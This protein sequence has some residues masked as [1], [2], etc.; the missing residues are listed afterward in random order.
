MDFF[1]HQSRAKSQS[2][3]LYFL[4]SFVVLV[5]CL[6]VFCLISWFIGESEN[7]KD[8]AW[9]P[10]LLFLT[11][12]V[13]SATIISVSLSKIKE[14][15]GGGW[16]IAN[17]LGGQLITSNSLHPLKRRI[18]NVV[19][20]MAIASGMPVPPVY[21]LKE[22][23]INAF[24]AGFS[25][26]DAVIGVTVGC[27]EKLNRD[28]LQGVM[29]H[30]FSHIL[31]GDMRINIR[32]SGIIFG[33][34][35][36]ARIGQSI[37]DH[38]D[39][40]NYSKDEKDKK[41]RWYLL[42]VGLFIIGIFGGYLGAIIRSAVSRQ[43]EYLADASAVQFTRNP[44]GI[45]EALER[46]GG[47]T[48]SSKIRNPRSRE[49][50]HMFFGPCMKNLLETHPP[51][52]KRIIRINPNWNKKFPNTNKLSEGKIFEKINFNLNQFSSGKPKTSS[53]IAQPVLKAE[54]IYEKLNRSNLN[55]AKNLI[56]N[57]PKSIKNLSEDPFGANCVLFAMILDHDQ[58]I[59]NKQLKIIRGLTNSTISIETNKVWPQ[60]EK[61]DCEKKFTLSEKAASQL[62]YLT[63]N[64]LKKF[65]MVFDKLMKEDGKLKLFEWSLSKVI[66]NKI[67]HLKSPGKRIHGRLSIKSR[68]TESSLILGAISHYGQ[69][70]VE[71]NLSYNEGFGFLSSTMKRKLPKKNDC[72][73]SN[74]NRALSRLKQLNPLAK[75]KLLTACEITAKHDKIIN[76]VEFQII[77]GVAS[78]LACPIGPL[79]R[80]NS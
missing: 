22:N 67:E 80:L 45:A 78:S 41:S 72:T 2:V 63:E 66:E 17:A 21:L 52:T 65:N 75:R 51:I 7:L 71:A 76:N 30:E 38:C 29:A 70:D 69:N 49:F 35:C 27:L 1:E 54:T 58:A 36:I 14:L 39:E 34:V 43:R 79:T 15:S 42:G 47:F 5:V 50:C 26:E 28:Q 25:T 37:M 44:S 64:Q 53:D 56:S 16:V 73:F 32:M 10:Y 33:I 19:E 3:K 23:G 13:V 31:N 9:S 48:K 12:I 77:R 18:L 8:L 59:R 4:F 55:Y 61:L 40:S 62:L 74:L 6:L 11:L 24:A 20:E 60:L 46:I 68:L 57:I